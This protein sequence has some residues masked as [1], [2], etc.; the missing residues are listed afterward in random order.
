[1]FVHVNIYKATLVFF[2]TMTTIDIRY[3]ITTGENR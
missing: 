1:M 2:D 3:K